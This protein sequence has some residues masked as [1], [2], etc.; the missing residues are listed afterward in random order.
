MYLDISLVEAIVLVA[1]GAIIL[2]VILGFFAF[3]ND[4]L[5]RREIARLR[6]ERRSIPKGSRYDQR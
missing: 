3:L 2:T 5:T 6:E 1:S 4:W